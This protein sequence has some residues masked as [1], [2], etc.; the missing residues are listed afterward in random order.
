V[1]C[2]FVACLLVYIVFVF[3]IRSPRSK[4][5][6]KRCKKKKKKKSSERFRQARTTCWCPNPI[7]SVF[8]LLDFLLRTFRKRR[9]VLFA[10]LGEKKKNLFFFFFF[11]SC[12]SFFSVLSLLV[13]TLCFAQRCLCCLCWRLLL[14]PPRAVFAEHRAVVVVRVRPR[15]RF[16]AV[17]ITDQ[18]LHS[19][20]RRLD[21]DSSMQWNRRR[22]PGGQAAHSVLVRAPRRRQQRGPGLR[23]RPRH[24]PVD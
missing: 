24:S 23:V 3:A 11:L 6:K 2:R 12:R 19:V 16:D 4:R 13:L 8:V 18:H 1:D 10:L 17:C 20:G 22:A 14:W 15:G 21:P 7:D 9:F 5:T